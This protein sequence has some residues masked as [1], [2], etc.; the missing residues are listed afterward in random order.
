MAPKGPIQIRAD[1]IA[2][3]GNKDARNGRSALLFSEAGVRNVLVSIPSE[4]LGDL[5]THALKCVLISSN[6][7]QTERDVHPE[8]AVRY[9]PVSATGWLDS[10]KSDAPSGHSVLEIHVAGI[11]LRFSAPTEA[12]RG[13]LVG[14]S[15]A[16][17]P[18][19]TSH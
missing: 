2:S 5:V 13:A 10:A 8:T 3:A 15:Q 14:L 19:R 1:F 12:W 17:A 11:P 18:D 7:P 4:Q 6:E 9:I 16:G